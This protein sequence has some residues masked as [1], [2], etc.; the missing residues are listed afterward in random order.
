ML[1]RIE[2]ILDYLE[3]GFLV[4]GLLGEE[5]GGEGLLVGGGDKDAAFGVFGLGAAVEADAGSAG[6]LAEDRQRALELRRVGDL[7]AIDESRDEVICVFEG[8]ADIVQTFYEFV[9]TLVVVMR[10]AI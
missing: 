2:G 9:K 1:A 3:A 10:G 5:A 6:D 8:V 4:G 7:Y